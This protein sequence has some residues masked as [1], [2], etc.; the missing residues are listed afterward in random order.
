[1]LFRTITLR[2]L[3][4]ISKTDASKVAPC[5]K[6]AIGVNPN[7]NGL[8]PSFDSKAADELLTR[9]PAFTTVTSLI[10]STVPLVI[11][12][13]ILRA[14]KKEVDDGSIPVAPVLMITSQGAIVPQRAGA[15]TVNFD[16]IP[17][18]SYNLPWVRTS[19]TFPTK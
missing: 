13:G 8:I 16:S 17:F 12:V 15:P 9:S 11:L 7:E 1:M 10:I 3:V 18:N 2:L 19:P 6:T 14:W 5:S 4:L